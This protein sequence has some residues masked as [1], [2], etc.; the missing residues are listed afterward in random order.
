MADMKEIIEGTGIDEAISDGA[1]ERLLDAM[2]LSP[3]VVAFFNRYGVGMGSDMAELRRMVSPV[4]KI[5]FSERGKTV[6]GASSARTAV[7]S[8][9]RG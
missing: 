9:G 4:V 1:I 8:I 2:F 5:W 7:R 3:R 6:S